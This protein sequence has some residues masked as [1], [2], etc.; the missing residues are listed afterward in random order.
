MMRAASFVASLTLAVVAACASGACTTKEPQA[1]TYFDA[2]IAPI[3]KTSCVHT[4]TGAGC[5]VADAKGNALGNL[6]LSS[7]EGIDHRRDLL[8]DYG[9]YGQPVVAREERP[10]VPGEPAALRRD[11]RRRHDGHQAHGRADPRSD[12]ERLRDAAP[13]DRERRDENNTGVPPVIIAHSPCNGTVPAA[14][15]FDAERRPVLGPTSRRSSR[16][17][18]RFSSQTCAAGNCHG[19]TVNALYLTCGIPPRR[20]AGTTSRPSSIS[21]RRRSRARCS[22]DR[23]RLFTRAAATTRAALSS[24]R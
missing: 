14:A 6:D 15:G 2:T 10:A 23:S 21:R 17:P 20:C 4:N 9:P 8:L 19:T 1:S 16:S 18:I 11:E 5:H 7:F 12:G 24:R 13:M 22:G 3:L